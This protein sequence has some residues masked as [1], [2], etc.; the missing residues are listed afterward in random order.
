MTRI[1]VQTIEALLAWRDRLAA[2]AK[3]AAGE[4]YSAAYWESVG[5][6]LSN[7]HATLEPIRTALGE[8]SD[9]FLARNIGVFVGVQG[10]QI[11]LLNGALICKIGRELAE[12]HDCLATLQQQLTEHII[13]Q[14]PPSG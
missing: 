2:A 11:S 13:C 6:L 12:T 5:E 3:A 14:P 7:S 10:W 9:E 8:A 4:C 1:E